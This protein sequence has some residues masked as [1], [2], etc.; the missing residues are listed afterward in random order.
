MCK[1]IAGVFFLGLVMFAFAL[2]PVCAQ[3]GKKVAILTSSGTQ[4]D[5]NQ[6]RDGFISVYT[7][8]YEA[9]D[10]GNNENTCRL[11]CKIIKAEEFDALLTIGSMALSCAQQELGELPTV[12]TMVM[13]A[14]SQLAE[15]SNLTGIRMLPSADV[16]LSF[17]QRMG[18]NRLG[19]LFTADENQQFVNQ[20]VAG[21]EGY[22]V[23]ILA[24][25][26]TSPKM[27]PAVFQEI[28]AEIDGYFFVLDSIYSIKDSVRFIIQNAIDQRI[29]TIAA[30]KAF[31]NE[32]ACFSLSADFVEMGR[33]SSKLMLRVLDKGI[34]ATAGDPQQVFVTVNEKVL[35][36]MG[37]SLIHI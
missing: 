37:L 31:V 34:T 30:S 1:H 6:V 26:V 33:Q 2:T 13:D 9:F 16:F 17:V 4:D 18:V 20:L 25:S 5:Y 27:V 10:C 29:V 23:Q 28:Q 15:R 32:R 22:G 24:R 11:R 36:A 35:N 19:L 14:D 3:T 21:A 8:E 7:G 12:F